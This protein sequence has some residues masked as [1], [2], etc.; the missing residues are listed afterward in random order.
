MI[1]TNCRNCTKEFKVFPYRLKTNT[2][3]FCAFSCRRNYKIGSTKKKKICQHCNVNFVKLRSGR[4]VRYC[5]SVC[6]GKS[7][8]RP[9]IIKK[10]YKRVLLPEHPR[11]DNKGYVR[12]HILIMEKHIGRYISYPEVIH[13]KNNDKLNND[14]SN[15]ELFATHKDHMQ[16]HK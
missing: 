16:M 10:G 4:D 1:S 3:L 12:E 2:R 8:S 15:L 9:Y 7:F 13:H 5:S 6:F 11:A 14:I